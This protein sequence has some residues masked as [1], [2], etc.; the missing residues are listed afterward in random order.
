M[1]LSVLDINGKSLENIDVDDAVFGISPHDAAE[2]QVLTAQLAALRSGTHSTKTRGEVRGSTRKLYGQ[3][4][5]GMARAGSSRS[6]TRRG[7][8]AAFGPKPR[9][10]S[11]K[12]PKNIRRLAIRSA[13]SRRVVEEKLTVISELGLEDVPS[14]KHVAGVLSNIGIADSVLIVTGNPDSIARK[15]ARNI[16]GVELIHADTLS[17]VQ[18]RKSRN[19]LLTVDAVRRCEALWGTSQSNEEQKEESTDA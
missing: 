9:N 7:G 8:G 4:G 19:V 16:D 10:Y 12:I 3:K 17:V 5:R 14:T 2:H 6:P 15:S 18:L 13:L 1:I 11:Q